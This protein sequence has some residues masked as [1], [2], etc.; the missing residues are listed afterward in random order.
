M[1]GMNSNRPRRIAIA[2]TAALSAASFIAQAQDE[3]D[4]LRYSLLSP[5]GTARSMGFGNALG[6]VGGDISTLSVNPAGIGIYR[7]SEILITP[8]LRFSTTDGNFLGS[9]ASDNNTRFTINNFG[10]VFT[11]VQRGKRYE[12]SDWK[13]FSFGFGVNRLADFNRNYAYSGVNSGA[14]SSSASEVFVVDADYNPDNLNYEGTPAWFGYQSYLIDYDSANGG[15]Y[16]NVP[17]WGNLRQQRYV[18]ERGGLNEYFLSFGGNY[19]EQLMLGLTVGIN[20]LR[21]IREASFTEVDEDNYSS[22]FDNFTLSERLSTTGVG[23]NAKIGAIYKPVDQFRAG[24]AIHTPTAFGIS[25]TYDQSLLAYTEGYAP[26]DYLLT[27]PRNEFSYS[28]TTPWRAVLSGTAMLGKMGFFSVDYEYVDYRSARYRFRSEDVAWA[29][30]YRELETA[31]NASIRNAYQ[32]ASNVRAGLELRFEPLLV[33]A[34]FGYYG[35]PYKNYSGG[36]R[37]DFS[38][39]LGFRFDQSFF[40]DLGFRHS[41][42]K[43][44]EQP[45]ALPTTGGYENVIV[46]VATLSNSATNVALTLGFKF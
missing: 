14:H 32:A 6:S 7:S 3:S 34:G 10:A 31:I 25:E 38:A 1:T 9:S 19:R 13:T 20:S 33:R 44:Q 45:Y 23:I 42:L 17:Y 36:N 12:K 11:N 26:E 15:W 37:L 27:A 21:Y 29:A 43:Q 4:A 30:T 46:P 8:V 2:L 41:R 28:L 39:G 22:V 24:V 40:M 18:R 5:Q 35:S 16:T